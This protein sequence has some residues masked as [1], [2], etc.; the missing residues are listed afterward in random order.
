MLLFVINIIPQICYI[1]KI[2]EYDCEITKSLYNPKNNIKIGSITYFDDEIMDDIKYDD[3]IVKQKIEKIKINNHN[4]ESS[5]SSIIVK[6]D[7]ICLKLL[8]EKELKNH[9]ILNNK[10]YKL[11]TEKL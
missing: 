3:M 9:I 11:S 2:F 7:E 10:I 6:N 4:R 1:F 8:G 5:I